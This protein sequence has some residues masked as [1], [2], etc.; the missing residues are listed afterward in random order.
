MGTDEYFNGNAGLAAQFGCTASS[1]G[2]GIRYGLPPENGNS[3]LVDIKPVPGLVLTNAYF[4][5]HQPVARVYE[6]EQPG[7]WLCS[8]AYGDITLGERGKKARRLE[9]GIHLLV[10]QGQPFKMIYGCEEDHRYTCAWV[11][12]DFLA[13]YLQDRRWTEPLT[14]TDALTWP[15]HYYNRPEITLAFEQL[16]LTIRGG[17]APWIYLESKVI[18]ILALILHSVEL[19]GYSDRYQKTRRVNYITY[20]NKKFL[21]QVKAELDKDIL[22]PPT[23]PQLAMLAGMG[24]T[25]LRQL[26]KSYY[27]MTISEYVRRG[28]MD[29][30]LRLLSH[31]EMSIQNIGTLLGYESHSKFTDAF[32][33]IHGF[34]PRHF[35][36]ALYL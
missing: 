2:K 6:I 28:K 35:R 30:A 27:R 33:K 14:I 3:W 16:K 20:Q 22:N 13:G 9:R 34:T 32:K 12:A 36:K 24:T 8:L 21:W 10:N 26:F 4:T 25:R 18:E 15:S 23:V 19:K 31:D 11:F 5:L 1:W 29:Y 7:L 17:M